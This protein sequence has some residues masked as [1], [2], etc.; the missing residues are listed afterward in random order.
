[1]AAFCPCLKSLPEAKL[2]SFA[3]VALAEK[4]SEQRNIDFVVQLLVLPPMKTYHEKEK[5]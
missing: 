2:K 5:T 1:V 4:I 3:L